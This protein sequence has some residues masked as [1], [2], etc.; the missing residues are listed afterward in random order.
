MSP[1]AVAT[2]TSR[3]GAPPRYL[4]TLEQM[5][6]SQAYRELAAALLFG[7]GRWRGLRRRRAAP[8]RP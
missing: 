6:K 7:D 5:M 4:E 3:E 8:P 1:T 2:Y